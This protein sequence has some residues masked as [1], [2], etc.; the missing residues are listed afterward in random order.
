MAPY[1]G[2]LRP[3]IATG[4]EAE[5][6]TMPRFSPEAIRTIALVG[7]GNAGKT[8]LVE[9]LLHKAGV[10]GAMG[11]VEKGSTVCD[12]DALEKSYQ[13]SLNASL[14]HMHHRDT[15]IH[16]ADTPGLP[17][18]I[19]RAIG[20]LPAVDTVA[21]VVNAQNGIQMITQRQMQ[22]YATRK[23]C[24]TVIVNEIDVDNS[25]LPGRLGKIQTAFGKECH[26]INLPAE[27]GKRVVDWF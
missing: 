3:A 1:Q 20:V 12:F 2:V 24:R 11:A 7:H 6:V 5:E 21:I 22:R 8:T 14:V 15:R 19:G 27:G 13:H 17:D 4:V 16:I 9:A 18:F 23:L 10:I 25:D 26:P